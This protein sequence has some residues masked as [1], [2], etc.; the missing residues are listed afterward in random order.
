[1]ST[2]ITT[3]TINAIQ[4][5]Y[6]K[7]KDEIYRRVYAQPF[8]DSFM[9]VTIDDKLML[10]E[11]NSNRMLQSYQKGHHAKGNLTLNGRKLEI[12]PSKFDFTEEPRRFQ[13]NNYL[14]HLVA[15]KPNT[16]VLPYQE[17]V[18]ST[19]LAQTVEDLELESKWGG[20]KLGAIPG[21]P[22]N[23]QDITD[24]FLKLYRDAVLAGK[25]VVYP[26]GPLAA[27]ASGATLTAVRDFV[28]TNLNRP[29]MRAAMWV[30]YTSQDVV[31]KYRQDYEATYA[32]NLR[33]EETWGLFRVDG[34]NAY[35][36][37]QDGLSGKDTLVMCRPGNLHVGIQ[38]PPEIKIEFVDREMKIQGDWGHGFQFQ[39]ES[40]SFVNEHLI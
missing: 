28:H 33:P 35:L 37:P 6:V 3:T 14:S 4:A 10:F 30:I 21:A 40:E 38:G 9:Q 36:L 13:Y 22:N 12:E 34:A 26:T 15:G 25:V 17:W 27:A 24:G 32:A 31:D 7:H 18:L 16:K 20:I 39:S 1:M 11:G 5:F 19:I 23:P 8:L 2:G 29:S